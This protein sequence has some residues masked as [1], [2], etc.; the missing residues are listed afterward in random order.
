MAGSPAREATLALRFC[1]LTLCPP[2]HR[3]AEG[4]P[5]GGR[6]AVQVREVEPPAE[7]RPIAWLLLTTV[8]V[9]SVEDA[10]ERVQ[11]YS[12]RWGIEISQPYY[13]SRESLFLAAA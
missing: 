6:W 10:S 8:A 5:A 3:K 11:W 9:D 2:R 1:P 7:G 13:G 4:L 12:C